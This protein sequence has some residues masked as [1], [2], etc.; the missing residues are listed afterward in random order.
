[1]TKR[2]ETLLRR[3]IEVL[4]DLLSALDEDRDPEPLDR[5]QVLRMVAETAQSALPDAVAE[6]RAADWPWEAVGRALG[7]SRQAAHERFAGL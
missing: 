2:R 1:M 5:V 4:R 7:T 6:A 3:K